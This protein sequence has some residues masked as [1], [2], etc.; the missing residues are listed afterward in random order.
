M[1]PNYV[2]LGSNLRTQKTKSLLPKVLLG[3]TQSVG[4]C[5]SCRPPPTEHEPTVNSTC[6]SV[7]AEPCMDPVW[8]LYGPGMDPVWTLYGPGMD[9]VIA[10]P[11]PFP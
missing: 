1:D 4:T 9:S 6:D 8:T 7:I 10:E 2:E 11:C 3:G 5:T